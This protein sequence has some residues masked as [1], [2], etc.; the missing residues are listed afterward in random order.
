M[1][2]KEF[3]KIISCNFKSVATDNN[4]S[5]RLN[6]RHPMLQTAIQ[7]KNVNF[8]SHDFSQQMLRDVMVTSERPVDDWRLVRLGW[9]SNRLLGKVIYILSSCLLLPVFV[10]FEILQRLFRLRLSGRTKAGSQSEIFNYF[11]Y[12]FCI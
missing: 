1:T 10:T 3:M 4:T 11:F 6:R 5:D 9:N 12:I 7:S 8:V 2:T